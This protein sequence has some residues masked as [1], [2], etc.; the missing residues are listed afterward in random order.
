[1]N[2]LILDY[3]NT[4]ADVYGEY[5]EGYIFRNKTREYIQEATEIYEKYRRGPD[6]IV[7]FDALLEAYNITDAHKFFEQNGMGKQLFVDT[8]PWLEELRKYT[9]VLKVVILTTGD[10]K[11]QE[12]KIDLTGL[13]NMVDE[14][15]ITRNRDKT[16]EIK[17]LIE[18]YNPK[19]TIFLDDRIHMTEADFDTPI[20]I[21]EMDRKGEK[22]GKGIVHSLW[23]VPFSLL[24]L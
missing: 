16:W 23:E 11:L 8:I 12:I 21:I 24:V 6:T 9:D 20:Q 3:D 13:R 15:V 7:M 1:M 4:L 2:L 22:S 10:E 14:V 17:K 19:K 18:K 5:G